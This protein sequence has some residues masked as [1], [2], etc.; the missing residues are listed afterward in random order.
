MEITLKSFAT[1]DI[2]LK[3]DDNSYIPNYF[4]DKVKFIAEALTAQPPF[5]RIRFESPPMF[6]QELTGD[7][8]HK[9]ECE[10]TDTA[11][12]LFSG[13]EGTNVTESPCKHIE[14]KIPKL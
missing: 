1:R 10:C 6:I 13:G 11:K 9:F 3:L 2:F 7:L 14:I 5:K 8:W 4:G 12:R